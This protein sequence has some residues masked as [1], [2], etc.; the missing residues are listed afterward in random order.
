MYDPGKGDGFRGIAAAFLIIGLWFGGLVIFLQLDT[1]TVPWYVIVGAILIQTFLY[2]GLFITAHDAMHGVVYPSNLRINNFIGRTAVFLYALFSYDMLHTK[3]WDHHRYPATE[4]DPDYHDGRNPGFFSWYFKFMTGYLKWWQ[5][6]GMAVIFN[7]LHLAL[8]VGVINLL[9]FWAL[10]AIA[11]T[12]QLFYFGT[13]LPHR[14]PG[15]G[16]SNRHNSTSNDYPVLMS[17]LTCYHFGYHLEHHEF[18]YVQWWKLP[19]V[20]KNWDGQVSKNT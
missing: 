4:K 12:W 14:E 9:L 19:K 17:F 10:P 15:G 7:I 1:A 8:N 6:L 3:H 18:P 20:R 11:S 5:I 13:F 16:H 2:T